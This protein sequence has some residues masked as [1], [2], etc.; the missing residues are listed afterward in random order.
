MEGE[1][2]SFGGFNSLACQV[3]TCINTY[4]DNF[5]KGIVQSKVGES[6]MVSFSD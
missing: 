4:I 6:Y 3:P 2:V 5:S 1:D